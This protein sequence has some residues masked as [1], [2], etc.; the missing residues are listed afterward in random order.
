MYEQAKR[1]AAMRAL[2]YVKP[3]TVLGLGSGSTAKVFVEL[4][5]EH[6]SER[7]TV[8]CVCTSSE[9]E[10][11]ARRFNLKLL[12]GQDFE[13][14]Q[15]TVDGADEVTPTLEMIKGGGGALM[16]ERIVAAATKYHVTIVD[17]SKM[18]DRLGQ[19]PL[20]IEIAPYGAQF[21]TRC[22]RD[23]VLSLGLKIAHAKIR[24]TLE[25]KNYV[26]DNGNFLFDVK[27][28]QI[29]D[30][31]ALSDA[32]YGVV[33]VV[34]HGLFVDLTDCVIVARDDGHIDEYRLSGSV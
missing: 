1:H 8:T 18:H 15:V 33:G 23:K 13:E 5:A 17:E 21:I 2:Q 30:S 16:R 27:V 4:F 7:A 25:G 31:V 14:A 11:V 3:H 10:A 12:D 9:T 29:N 26:T 32:L 34:D 24:K 22:I 28:D 20:P 19:F 6:F